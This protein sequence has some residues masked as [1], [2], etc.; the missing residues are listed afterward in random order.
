MLTGSLAEKINCIERAAR[1]EEFRR[2][3]E[4]I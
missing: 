1:S 2:S 3:F 4:E